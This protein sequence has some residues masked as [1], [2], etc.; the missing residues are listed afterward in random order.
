MQSL[1]W[2]TTVQGS[3]VLIVSVSGCGGIS[4]CE[5]DP[6]NDT[7]IAS[8]IRLQTSPRNELPQGLYI[9]E[10]TNHGLTHMQSNSRPP[11]YTSGPLFAGCSASRMVIQKA[12]F[13][14]GSGKMQRPSR[15]VPLPSVLQ[16]V[17][18]HRGGSSTIHIEYAVYQY[19]DRAARFFGSPFH[20]TSLA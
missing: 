14:V 12:R 10:G 19:G 16:L 15:G 9:C 7:L 18:W 5:Y 6:H 11:Q 17:A 1:C 2:L 4:P 3:F 8:G 13:R 20:W